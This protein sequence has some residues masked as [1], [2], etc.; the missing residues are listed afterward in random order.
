MS[1]GVSKLFLC[2]VFQVF[3]SGVL[4]SSFWRPRLEKNLHRLSERLTPLG[5]IRSQLRAPLKLFNTIVLWCSWSIRGPS[6]RPQF[7]QETPVSHK[8]DAS[9]SFWLICISLLCR[10]RFE[11]FW[12]W[13]FLFT[14]RFLQI[15][16]YWQATETFFNK[17]STVQT[18]C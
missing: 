3:I 17:I 10:S 13:S 8:A 11:Q 4:H 2:K 9:F 1:P 7:W 6:I 12:D 18:P 14:D 16:I 5:I 15:F